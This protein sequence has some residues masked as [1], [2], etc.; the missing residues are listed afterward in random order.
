[1]KEI[2][3][4]CQYCQAG[5]EGHGIGLCVFVD[6]A[7]GFIYVSYASKITKTWTT[8]SVK[9][10]NTRLSVAAST[11]YFHSDNKISKLIVDVMMYTPSI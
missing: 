6:I 1:M 3:E 4:L 8:Y 2:S 11:I 7:T 9:M 5:I 10:V